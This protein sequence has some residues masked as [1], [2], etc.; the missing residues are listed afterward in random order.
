MRFC[1]ILQEDVRKNLVSLFKKKV[2]ENGDFKELYHS[3]PSYEKEMKNLA[4]F[5]TQEARFKD[6]IES[7]DIT[8]LTSY[9]KE[10]SLC[11][12]CHPSPAVMESHE[13]SGSKKA[14]GK[15]G[16]GKKAEAN[17]EAPVVKEADGQKWKLSG[18]LLHYKDGCTGRVKYVHDEQE[19][20]E[21]K[22]KNFVKAVKLISKEEK[23]ITLKSGIPSPGDAKLSLSVVT[24][25]WH[26]IDAIRELRNT[27]YGHR[28]VARMKKQEFENI[29]DEVMGKYDGMKWDKTEI[30]RIKDCKLMII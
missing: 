8:L 19:N 11:E 1:W 24:P 28:E 13:K 5:S 7:W 20:V 10:C 21:N 26:I 12:L 22:Y 6:N 30:Q 2:E 4:K 17:S 16:A 14:G 18:Q 25:E 27:K 23:S 3:L 15:K 29:F 9:L